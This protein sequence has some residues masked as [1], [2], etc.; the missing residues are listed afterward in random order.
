M[1][2]VHVWGPLTEAGLKA[3]GQEPAPVVPDQPAE[4]PAVPTRK[5]KSRWG[6][7]AGKATEE[8]TGKE[9]VLFPEVVVLSNG[10]Q[11]RRRGVGAD[12]AASCSCSLPKPLP[13]SM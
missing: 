10:Q 5:R 1:G 13:C 3:T 12:W 9:I 8:T 11:V 2:R 4:A 6:D 7:D